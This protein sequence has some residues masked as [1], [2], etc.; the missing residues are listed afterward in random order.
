MAA[1]SGLRRLHRTLVELTGSEARADAIVDAAADAF[2]AVLVQNRDLLVERGPRP[3]LPYGGGI[4]GALA[5]LRDELAPFGLSVSDVVSGRPTTVRLRADCEP[6]IVGELED[7]W[8]VRLEPNTEGA[9]AAVL[10]CSERNRGH[11]GFSVSGFLD[12]PKRRT[13]RAI[14]PKLFF[15]ILLEEARV[16]V[17]TRAAL[18]GIY[19]TLRRR[20]KA[21]RFSL[22]KSEGALRVMLPKKKLGIDLEQAVLYG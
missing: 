6:V 14:S 4:E 2:H 16:W 3:M 5:V 13:T 9:V 18:Q 19:A 1:K 15:F 10:F 17:V 21:P 7:D 11:A 8:F 12:S 22:A 20:W